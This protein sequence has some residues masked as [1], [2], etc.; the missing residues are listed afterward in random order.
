MKMSSKNFRNGGG[1]G[2]KRLGN[3]S[4]PIALI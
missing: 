1:G 2:G 4:H 3:A